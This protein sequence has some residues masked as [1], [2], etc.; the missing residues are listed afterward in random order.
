M[1][2]HLKNKPETQAE[3]DAATLR[4]MV[5][6]TALC[7]PEA[8]NLNAR[9]PFRINIHDGA[10]TGAFLPDGAGAIAVQCELT[11]DVI[12]GN[13]RLGRDLSWAL[14]NV[15]IYANQPSSISE[16][17]GK[18]RELRECNELFPHNGHQYQPVQ[19]LNMFRALGACDQRFVRGHFT[20]SEPIM[21]VEN[22]QVLALSGTVARCQWRAFLLPVV[23]PLQFCDGGGL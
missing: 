17:E 23:A 1:F 8:D 5:D 19:I 6:F 21:G 15:H 22:A 7:D 3:I 14:K 16:F 10:W 9:R 13:T 20:W 4:A 11:G 18:L 12:S 2:Q